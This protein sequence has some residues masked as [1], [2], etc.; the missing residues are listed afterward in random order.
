MK[1]SRFLDS[2]ILAV[3]KQ[4]ESSVSVPE[5]SPSVRLDIALVIEFR[6]L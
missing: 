4:A 6:D 2:Q 1:K 3:L 5:L